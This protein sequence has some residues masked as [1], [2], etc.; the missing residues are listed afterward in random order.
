MAKRTAAPQADPVAQLTDLVIS[1]LRDEGWSPPRS[2][3][4]E[5]PAPMQT[6]VLRVPGELID[7]LDKR[8]PNRSDT[9]RGILAD[10]LGLP[11]PEPSSGTA[12]PK[13]RR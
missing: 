1:R 4:V 3:V 6:L 8:G 5:R 13:R 12:A 11:R 2:P 7:A 9:A 10:A